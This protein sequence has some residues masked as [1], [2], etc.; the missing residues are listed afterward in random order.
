MAATDLTG[1]ETP[2]MGR[3]LR[4]PSPRATF[5]PW[6]DSGKRRHEAQNPVGNLGNH[7]KNRD[8]GINVAWGGPENLGNLV[9]HV[10]LVKHGV[11][12]NRAHGG[13]V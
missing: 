4:V 11:N 3:G 9:A 2:S 8:S 10:A 5:T 13:G 12:L 6:G 7:S 1:G